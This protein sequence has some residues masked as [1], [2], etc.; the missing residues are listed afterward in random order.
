VERRP[1]LITGQTK[2]PRGDSK[3]GKRSHSFRLQTYDEEHDAKGNMSSHSRCAK[4]V[5]VMGLFVE[6]RNV[7]HDMRQE[8]IEAG[9][10]K[11]TT[12][13]SYFPVAFYWVFL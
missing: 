4:N 1:S 7:R 10:K 13:N 3:L 2:N 12:I 8:E 5:S 11:P 9:K 6:D